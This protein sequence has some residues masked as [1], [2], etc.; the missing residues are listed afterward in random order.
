M[1]FGSGNRLA[2]D[3]ATDKVLQMNSY[4]DSE[5]FTQR[6][7]FDKINKRSKNVRNVRGENHE[8][9]M[10]MREENDYLS[11]DEIESVKQELIKTFR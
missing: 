6:S 1:Q 7:D 10:K 2:V 9:I 11:E 5:F 8:S 4:Q 3:Q